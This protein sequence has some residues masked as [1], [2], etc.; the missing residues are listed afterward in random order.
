MAAGHAPLSEGEKVWLLPSA[1]HTIAAIIELVIRDAGGL[2]RMLAGEGG[3][4]RGLR[5]ASRRRRRGKAVVRL[6]LVADNPFCIFRELFP[7]N[8]FGLSASR[9]SVGDRRIIFSWCEDHAH[10]GSGALAVVH[11]L[12]SLSEATTVLRQVRVLLG[13]VSSGSRAP[14]ELACPRGHQF[15]DVRWNLP[16]ATQT[17]RQLVQVFCGRR[18]VLKRRA[19]AT[20]IQTLYS[21]VETLSFPKWRACGRGVILGTCRN[22]VVH[23][24]VGRHSCCVLH[25]RLTDRARTTDRVFEFSRYRLLHHQRAPR[26]PALTKAEGSVRKGSSSGRRPLFQARVCR[27]GRPSVVKAVSENGIVVLLVCVGNAVVGGQE[28]R[29]KLIVP[30]QCSLVHEVV[31]VRPFLV[32]RASSVMEESLADFV[33]LSGLI[34][35]RIFEGRPNVLLIF[36]LVVLLSCSGLLASRC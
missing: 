7:E 24:I 9:H 22:L 27:F 23:D 30:T 28:E 4:R 6:V 18:F 33:F 12:P 29:H 10:S 11:R 19:D 26:T 16:L 8:P 17:S 36:L 35:A 31:P 2:S 3:S 34:T 25:L 20:A 1:A 32:V 15:V 21:K 14:I 13:V 5:S